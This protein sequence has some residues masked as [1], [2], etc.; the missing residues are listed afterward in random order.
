MVSCF[1]VFVAI[2]NGLILYFLIMDMTED[3]KRIFFEAIEKNKPAHLIDT[4]ITLQEDGFLIHGQHFSTKNRPVYL[5]ATGKASQSMTSALQ[6]MFNLIDENILCIA[7]FDRNQEPK[8]NL[9]YASHP[10]PDGKS[11]KA[12]D[13]LIKFI[14]NIPDNAIVLFAISGGTSALVSKPSD[15][16]SMNEIRDVNK[17]LLHS[18]A[19]IH[20]INAVRKHLSAV[21]GGRLLHCFQPNITLINLIISDVPG[22]DPQIIGSG[23]T[24]SDS[25]TFEEAKQVLLKYDLWN[26]VSRSVR[27]HIEK[28]LDGEISD[29]LK[30]GEEPLREHQSVI[31]GSAQKFAR[32]MSEIAAEMGYEAIVADDYYNASVGEVIKHIMKDIRSVSSGTHNP[33]AFIYY[34]ESTMRITGVGKGGRNQEM[35]M[36]AAVELDGMNNVIWLSADTDGHDGPTDAAGAIVDG[37]TIQKARKKGLDVDEFIENNGSYHF[38]KKMR[39]HLITGVTG[40]NLMDIILVL[41]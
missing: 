8:K 33:K 31:I 28:E 1:S 21:K 41:F 38:H 7:P 4:A 2:T 11:K 20:E 23:L 5:I 29:T 22:D 9:I 27:H 39:T 32:S 14:K 35:A 37:T 12:A 26:E 25:S 36:R 40:N 30:A 3:A 6:N 15:G 18:G 24:V 13:A 19:S 16:V 10:Y 17:M 34:G